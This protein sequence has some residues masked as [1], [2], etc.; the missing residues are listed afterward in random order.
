MIK[1]LAI[2]D[3][4]GNAGGGNRFIRC[5]LPALKRIQPGTEIV[6]FCNK[7]SIARDQLQDELVD[8]GVIIKHLHTKLIRIAQLVYFIVS[9]STL[10]G[11]HSSY[12]LPSSIM[13]LLRFEMELKITHYD[14]A[15]FPWPFLLL[16]PNLKCP[17]VATFHDFNFRYYFSGNFTFNPFQQS[18]LAQETPIWLKRCF[19]V[20]STHFMERELKKFYPVIAHQPEVIH[21][22]SLSTQTPISEKDA[23]KIVSD[24]FNITGD[25]ILYPTNMC[26]H[27]NIGP[28]IQAVHILRTMNWNIKLILTGPATERIIGCSSEIGIELNQKN[29]DVVGLG[30]V[31]NLQMDALIQCAKAVVSSS[32]YEA[33]N[34]PGIDAWARAVPVAMSDIPP[35]MEHIEV[36]NVKAHVFD[37]RN[38]H[39]IA[40]KIIAILSD[41]E[42]AKKEALYSQKAMRKITWETVAEKYL[43]VFNNAMMEAPK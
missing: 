1:R 27:K 33:G 6:F 3:Q 10:A 19:P 37:P 11:N 16:C 7:A 34:G 38:P 25:Y 24:E 42:K 31:S 40:N 26:S 23:K 20:V 9:K 12:P 18:L 39:D 13:K 32:L 14:V 5:L 35:F 28:L 29:H 2:V 43:A 8:S 17:M 30:Y 4:I 21:L 22:A 36:Q 15:F 41:P